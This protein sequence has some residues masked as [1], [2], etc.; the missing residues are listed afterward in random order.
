MVF[1]FLSFTV[2]VTWSKCMRCEN[3]EVF[4][5]L[6]EFSA[7]RNKQLAFFQKRKKGGLNFDGCQV[8]VFYDDPHTTRDCL[9][10]NVSEEKPMK[11]MKKNP[12]F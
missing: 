11:K 12:K 3:L 6:D 4:V 9:K 10:K 2:H 1:F 5:R 7:A 8:D